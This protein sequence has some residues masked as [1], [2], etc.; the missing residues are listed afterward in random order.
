MPVYFYL[1]FY[2]TLFY[3]DEMAVPACRLGKLLMSFFVFLYAESGIDINNAAA[4]DSADK[5]VN[6]RSDDIG[7]KSRSPGNN[8]VA[9]AYL[10][11]GHSLRIR[12]IGRAHV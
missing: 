12:E 9:A 7:V 5:R 2:Y 8:A 11:I 3:L 1:L 10:D 4:V 6:G